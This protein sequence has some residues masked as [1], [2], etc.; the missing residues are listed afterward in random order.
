VKKKSRTV[1]VSFPTSTAKHV[2]KFFFD[3]L[4]GAQRLKALNDLNEFAL[5]NGCFSAPFL[6]QLGT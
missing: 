1:Y 2:D 6:L 3:G 5:K 4:N